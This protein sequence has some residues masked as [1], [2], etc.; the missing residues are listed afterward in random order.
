MKTERNDLAGAWHLIEW[1]CTLDGQPHSHPFG[2]D[3]MGQIIYSANGQMSAILMRRGRRN[4]ATPNLATGS[5][6][7]K[8]SAIDGYV[9][10]AG[11]WEIVG[12]S[13]VHHVRFSLLPNWIGTDLKR[14]IRWRDTPR[15]RELIL[16]TAP[17]LTRSGRTVINRLR[18]RR[19]E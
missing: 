16:E 15:G 9:S 5:V 12:E 1:D 8:A 17:E 19:V 13:V 14:S 4:F 7:E 10:Y 11:A 2:A 18:W 6:E 3:A